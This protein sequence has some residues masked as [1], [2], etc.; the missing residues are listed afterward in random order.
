MN[1]YY[2]KL[3]MPKNWLLFHIGLG[4]SVLNMDT[5][6]IYTFFSESYQIKEKFMNFLDWYDLW[7]RDEYKERYGL[8]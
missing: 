5:F 2:W 1:E 3:G 7:I 4:K 8:H 6:E